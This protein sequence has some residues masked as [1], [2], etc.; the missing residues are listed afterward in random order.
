MR[1]YRHHQRG[2]DRN[3]YIVR[4]SPTIRTR[5]TSVASNLDH[6]I[7]GGNDCGATY[8]PGFIDRFLITA[9]AYH[10][11]A[12]IVINKMDL[13]KDKHTATARR[14]AG[15]VWKAGYE[16]FPI[17]ALQHRKRSGA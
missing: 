13:L 17:V 1:E 6:G 14:M 8:T 11:P 3:N 2:T 16:V 12:I 15:Y 4:V 9:E 7:D 5:N 10:I